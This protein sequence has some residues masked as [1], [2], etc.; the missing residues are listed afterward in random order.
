MGASAEIVRLGS[1]DAW[2]ERLRSALYLHSTL[3]FTIGDLLLE[4]ELRFPEQWSQAIPESVKWRP[5]TLRMYMYVCSRVVNRFTEQLSFRH[6][7]IVASLDPQEQVAALEIAVQDNM[8]TRELQAYLKQPESP[9]LPPE[10]SN[11]PDPIQQPTESML[12][13]STRETALRGV[14]PALSYCRGRLGK[15]WSPVDQSN[16]EDLLRL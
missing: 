1:Y 4:G 13:E 16:L 8:T 10:P 15:T 14:C 12:M 6:H 7:Q 2:E 9:V 11:D 3:Q 5:D